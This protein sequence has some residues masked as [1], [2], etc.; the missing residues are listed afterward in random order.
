RI[1]FSS[2]LPVLQEILNDQNAILL[3]PDDLGA[4]VTALSKII[5]NPHRQMEMG[6]QARE[7][8]IRYSWSAR[9]ARIFAMEDIKLR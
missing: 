7:D 4:W 2:H 1:I 3:P 8:S 9:A 6:A 5:D